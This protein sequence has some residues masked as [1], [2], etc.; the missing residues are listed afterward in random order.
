[1][2]AGDDRQHLEPVVA[3]AMRQL[4]DWT[5]HRYHGVHRRLRNVPLR[6]KGLRDPSS[7]SG[8]IHILKNLKYH[9]Y[10]LDPEQLR[11]WAIGHGWKV[12]DANDLRDYAEGVRSGRRYHTVA[13]PFGFPAI[14]RWR[15]A[16]AEVG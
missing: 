12:S 6:C 8:T 4:T 1:M 9:G 2:S 16:A 5:Y 10:V 15:E 14:D 13:D 3:A 11:N 7:R